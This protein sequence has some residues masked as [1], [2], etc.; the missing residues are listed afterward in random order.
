MAL[1]AYTTEGVPRASNIE[2]IAAFLH[3]RQRWHTNS[4]KMLSRSGVY[5][6]LYGKFQAPHSISPKHL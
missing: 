4:Q 2:I 1:D 6:I 3:G 5:L